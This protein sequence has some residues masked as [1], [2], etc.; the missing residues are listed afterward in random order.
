MCHRVSLVAALACLARGWLRGAVLALLAVPVASGLNDALFKH[1]FHR[2][3]QGALTYPSGH[4]AAAAALA[5]ALTVL[6]LQTRPAGPKQAGVRQPLLNTL[7]VAAPSI[8]TGV[9][10]AALGAYA[11]S[12]LRFRGQGLLFMAYVALLLIPWTLT[13]IPLFL[14]I[15]KLGLFNTEWA[16]VL[17]LA[18]GARYRWK[19]QA[20]DESGLASG[21]SSPAAFETELDQTSGW[22]ASWIGLGPLRE[23]FRPPSEPGPSDP[24]DDGGWRPVRV[25]ER[26]A[27]PL[28]A[29]PGPPIRVTEEI[30]P[31]SVPTDCPQRDDLGS[32][33]LPVGARP[34]RQRLAGR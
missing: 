14:T 3:Y 18:G 8:V 11:F 25:R 12:Q 32:R 5:A 17:P 29:D 30:A 24:V 34:G 2:T 6:L 20:W 21:W 23:E 27:T 31:R 19:V 10:S 33:H 1:L 13:L 28:V 15:E 9:T 26:D 7:I 22:H 16:L 4:T